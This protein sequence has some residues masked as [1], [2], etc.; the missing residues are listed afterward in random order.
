MMGVQGVRAQ[1]SLDFNTINNE[2]Y[3]L[4]IAEEWDSTIKLGNRALEQDVDY[5]YLRLRI[6]IAYYSK[7]NYRKAATHFRKALGFNPGDPLTLEYLYFSRLFAGQRER[8]RLVQKDFMGELARRLGRKPQPLEQ[9]GIGFVYSARLTGDPLEEQYQQPPDQPTG[10]QFQTRYF[11]NTTLSLSHGITP[12][13]SLSHAYNHL[14][15]YNYLYY[16]DGWGLLR[17]ESQHTRQNQ[18]Y[19]S[20]AITTRFGLTFSPMFHLVRMHYQS[21]VYTGQGN[22]TQ[23]VL[24]YLD[25]TDIATGLGLGA[26]LGP[27]DVNLGFYYANL[28]DRQ[29]L[30]HRVGVTWY[31]LGNLNL[32]AGFYLNTQ[33]EMSTSSDTT[34]FIPELHAGVAIAEKVW[35]DL[36]ASA[37][38]MTHYLENNGSIIYNS[39]GEVIRRKVSCT[40]T[41]PVSKKGSLAYLGGRW[42]AHTSNFYSFTSQQ[43]GTIY[44]IDYQTISIYGGL[45]WRF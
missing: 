20:P 23:P 4:V 31:P 2:S 19:I 6:G 29:Q 30:Q 9:A 35:I 45:S 32:Y 21:P 5:F 40:I 24:Q 27:V 16:Y 25:S 38:S 36:N 7:K 10:M 22:N 34:R 1:D 17:E 33:Y 41:V 12:G 37:G 8:A 43:A 42:C 26:N 14:S 28:N 11:T 15:K 39:F 3:R 13:F 44:D 18:Y